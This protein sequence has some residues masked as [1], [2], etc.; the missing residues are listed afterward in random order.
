LDLMKFK[1]VKLVF[2][3]IL[4]LPVDH[5]SWLHHLS[6]LSGSKSQAIHPLAL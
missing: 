1:V 2:F 3:T 5:R 4:L 6:L